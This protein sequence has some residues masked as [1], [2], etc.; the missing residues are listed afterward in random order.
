[1]DETHIISECTYFSQ[2][3]TS[4]FNVNRRTLS[5]QIGQLQLIDKLK[6]DASFEIKFLPVVQPYIRLK[7][8]IYTPSI[9]ITL[10]RC[11]VE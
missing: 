6:L 7:I 9:E 1:M 11:E 4:R 5:D 8:Y 10:K 3:R 2:T